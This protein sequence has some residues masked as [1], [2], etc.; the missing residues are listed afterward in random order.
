MKKRTLALALTA[1]LALSLLGAAAL[2]AE[3]GSPGPD[4]SAAQSALYKPLLLVAAGGAE[5]DYLRFKTLQIL[6]PEVRLV[7]QG[8]AMD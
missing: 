7:P 2:A 8:P 1:A 3:G 6:A 5:E 4:S